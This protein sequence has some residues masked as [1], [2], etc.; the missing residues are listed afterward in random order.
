MHF[1]GHA[2]FVSFGPQF[3]WKS[4]PALERVVS[5]AEIP[6]MFIG[7]DDPLKM[8]AV[9]EQAD[10]YVLAE[11][12]SDYQSDDWWK[13]FGNAQIYTIPSTLIDAIED[14]IADDGTH[15]IY[16]VDGKPV[17]ALQKGLNIIKYQNGTTKKV[18]VK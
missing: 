15:Q 12:V 17:E 13:R 10:L 1:I 18:L 2:F 11:S 4:F 3:F 5:Q 14:G 16:T 9:F 7:T 6:P 8:N